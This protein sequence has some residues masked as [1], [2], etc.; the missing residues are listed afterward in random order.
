MDVVRR[1]IERLINQKDESAIDDFLAPDF[2]D[3]NAPP[4]Q[5]P[6]PEGAR[7]MLQRVLGA[8]DD[9]RTELD[10]IIVDGDKVAV[11][12]RAYATHVG[13]FM[14]FP[15]TG[16]RLSWTGISIYRVENGKIVERWGLI[17]HQA[18]LHQLRG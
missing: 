17:D 6:G 2:V 15:G 5:P 9:L 4:D 12:H 16:K 8:L 18:L 13:S 14:G 3:H 10:D 11:R 7:R 1:F